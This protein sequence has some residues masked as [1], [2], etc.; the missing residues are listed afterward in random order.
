MLLFLV[1]W[2]L[3]TVVAEELEVGAIENDPEEEEEP[4]EEDEPEEDDPCLELLLIFV[5]PKVVSK[6]VTLS[7]VTP[8]FRL[9]EEAFELPFELLRMVLVDTLLVL[10]EVETEVEL[11]LLFD[12]SCALG[13]FGNEFGEL[14]VLVLE[15]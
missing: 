2:I 8:W 11:L 12:N 14:L 1:P 3:L 9:L 5:L 6:V 7:K 15:E 13:M 10:E 4:E